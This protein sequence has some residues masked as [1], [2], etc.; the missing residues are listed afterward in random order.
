M[1][2][3]VL[4]TPTDV[5]SPICTTSVHD[6]RRSP[7]GVFGAPGAPGSDGMSRLKSDPRSLDPLGS[8]GSCR[9]MSPALPMSSLIDGSAAA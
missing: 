2:F 5:E 3:A 8:M 9:R 4:S 1:T 7:V 6:V